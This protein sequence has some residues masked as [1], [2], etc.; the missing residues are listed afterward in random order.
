MRLPT[1][2]ASSR[3]RAVRPKGVAEEGLEQGDGQDHRH[4]QGDEGEDP[5]VVGEQRE[6]G[7]G[8]LDIGQVQNVGQEGH[9]LPQRDVLDHQVFHQLVQGHQDSRKDGVQHGSVSFILV[10]KIYPLFYHVPSPGTTG[11]FHGFPPNGRSPLTAARRAPTMG[12]ETTTVSGGDDHGH[13][14]TAENDPAGLSRQG[15]RVRY[16]WGGATCAAPSATTADWWK[17]PCRQS[18][19]ARSCWP[20]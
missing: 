13:S 10:D 19:T 2:P 3:A 16:F 9:V 8:I 7:S 11:N 12:G 6:G 18:W 4:D 14:R 5:G 1:A 17:A 15:W 20:F